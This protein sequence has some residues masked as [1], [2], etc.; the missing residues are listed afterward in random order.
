MQA[1]F[2]LF[3]LFDKFLTT[4][5]ICIYIYTY[6][7]LK[8]YDAINE[9]MNRCSLFETNTNIEEEEEVDDDDDEE[10]KVHK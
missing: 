1:A 9:K 6:I 8:S 7:K 4:A 3:F 2:F 5:Y 10:E